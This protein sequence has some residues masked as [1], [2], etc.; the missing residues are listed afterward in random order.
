MDDLLVD[1]RLESTQ[2]A[3]EPKGF[4]FEQAKGLHDGFDGRDVL[5]SRRP[6]NP[7]AAGSRGR[8]LD[9]GQISQP[10]VFAKQSAGLGPGPVQNHQP[11]DRRL[12]GPI[13]EFPG[14]FSGE[15]QRRARGQIKGNLQAAR[16]HRPRQEN[17]GIAQAETGDP[18]GPDGVKAL[19]G[20]LENRDPRAVVHLGNP[21]AKAERRRLEAPITRL[22]RGNRSGRA[23]RVFLR[24]RAGHHGMLA[25]SRGRRRPRVFPGTLAPVLA[26]GLM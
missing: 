11:W 5:S 14:R 18:R 20:V 6:A 25:V 13:R 23:G 12:L 7:V 17:L 16:R 21:A 1:H 3:I 19:A 10:G 24:R 4:G 15:E 8:Q 9:P 2:Q 22:P 26:R